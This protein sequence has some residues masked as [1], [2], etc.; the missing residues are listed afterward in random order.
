MML[1]ITTSALATEPQ[2]I[3]GN[4]TV[5]VVIPE[6]VKRIAANTFYQC[7]TLTSVTL[8]N[9][10]E[11][12]GHA[13]F[14]QCTSLTE[15]VIPDSVTSIDQAVFIGCS[16][17]KSVTL[18]NGLKEIKNLFSSCTSLTEIVFPNALETIGEN[19]F[20]NC[21]SLTT[22]VIPNSVK[23]IG[24]YAFQNCTNLYSVTI[25]ESVENI[26]TWAFR[27]CYKLIEVINKSN[28][29]TVQSGKYFHTQ[30]SNGLEPESYLGKYALK[31]FNSDDTYTNIFTVDDNGFVTYQGT[32]GKILVNYVGTQSEI[33]IPSD[34]VDI[35][36]YALY[37]I[38]VI[39]S[40][41][42]EDTS[43]WYATNNPSDWSNKNNGTEIDVT[44]TATNVTN[45]ADTYKDYY[46]YKK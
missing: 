36:P 29:I 13:A 31:V 35:R 10:L 20:Y 4:D 7:S 3:V 45:F 44:N 27:D 6:G 25:G 21:A 14:G 30:A 33:I 46:W 11:S 26:D 5:S 2:V 28:K 9:G 43:T 1:S 37:K 18:G 15:I 34:V 40:I 32:K 22:V 17:L 16:K 8:P 12:I 19:T 38:D 24:K 39:T 41:T 23:S 42:F